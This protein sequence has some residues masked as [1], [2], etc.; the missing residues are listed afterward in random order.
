MSSA[1]A[2]H[3][4]KQIYI[5]GQHFCCILHF[6]LQLLGLRVAQSFYKP[7]LYG[8]KVGGRIMG[9]NN[10]K[11]MGSNGSNGIAVE[12]FEV[13]PCCLAPLNDG[14]RV[15]PPAVVLSGRL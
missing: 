7:T 10:H 11:D 9:P 2:I 13:F 6:I 8:L 14:V 5:T 12:D 4:A 3:L 1:I 15:L